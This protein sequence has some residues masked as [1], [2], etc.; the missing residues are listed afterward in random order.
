[1]TVP[2]V[3]R[4]VDP[5]DGDGTLTPGEYMTALHNHGLM[6]GKSYRNL[7]PFVTIT[8]VGA[9]E[10]WV[11]NIMEK[12]DTDGDGKISRQEFIEM[13]IKYGNKPG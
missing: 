3:E 12:I 4:R 11:R 13:N 6:V 2:G 1:M 9:D 7:S 10:D 5:Q 8:V